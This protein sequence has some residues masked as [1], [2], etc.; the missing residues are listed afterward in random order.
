MSRAPMELPTRVTG[1]F[2]CAPAARMCAS[3][4]PAFCALWSA[5][6]QAVSI[7]CSQKCR[8]LPISNQGVKAIPKFCRGMARCCSIA[9]T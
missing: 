6:D 1:L 7:S 4:L 3:S 9:L 5:T 2:P 8:M